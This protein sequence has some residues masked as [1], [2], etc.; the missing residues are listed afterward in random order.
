MFSLVSNKHV[1]S[2]YKIRMIYG[3]GHLIVYHFVNVMSYFNF[4]FFLFS[5]FATGSSLKSEKTT[6][7]LVGISRRI[8]WLHDVAV[9]WSSTSHLSQE[10][11]R[12]CSRSVNRIKIKMWCFSCWEPLYF[13]E[14]RVRCATPENRARREW[15]KTAVPSHFSRDSVITNSFHELLVQT[16]SKSHYLP[17]YNCK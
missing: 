17:K 8:R 13:V 16:G 4:P 10:Q 14:D 12:L 9:N 1:W 15:E 2:S 6:L 3:F 11:D 5:S 7:Q